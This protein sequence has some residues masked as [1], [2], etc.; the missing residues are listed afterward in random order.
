MTKIPSI[1]KLFLE[2]QKKL[3]AKAKQEESSKLGILRAGN[4]GMITSE[5]QIIGPC[6][7][8]T[9]L[10]FKGVDVKGL[11]DDGDF[12]GIQ[13]RELMFEAGRSNEDLWT[14]VLKQAWSGT[15]LRESEIATSWTTSQGIRVTGRPDVVLCTKEGKPV[16]G[17][18]LKLVSGFWTAYNVLCKGQPKFNHLLQ[19][20]HYSWQLKVPFEVWYA[21]RSD[22]HT[23]GWISSQLPKPGEPGSDILEYTYY[24]L[25]ADQSKTKVAKWQWQK[26]TPED[27]T[28]EP[29][30]ILPALHGYRI[31]FKPDGFLYYQD[32]SNPKETWLKSI[33]TL[34]N[35]Q[36]YYETIADGIEIVPPEPTLTKANGTKENYKAR[37]YCPLG[38]L[39]CAYQKG[40]PIDE[41]TD[42]IKKELK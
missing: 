39:C 42:A 35:I 5:G 4:T 19:A 11:E 15:I 37:D 1:Y 20:A 32:I 3:L 18:E 28:A 24:R 22:Y 17:L 13:G 6:L 7:G 36:R 27:R 41:W 21:S 10:R 26:L 34:D 38:P 12:S 9:Y 16:L 2:G 23:V 25:N 30:K 40:K 29:L 14:E 33:I 8:L 31:E